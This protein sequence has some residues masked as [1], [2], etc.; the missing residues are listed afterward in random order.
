MIDKIA[1]TDPRIPIIT[2]GTAF[3]ADVVKKVKVTS[4]T[5]QVNLTILSCK[6]RNTGA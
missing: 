4:L 6:N 5:H 2:V 1:V 3:T